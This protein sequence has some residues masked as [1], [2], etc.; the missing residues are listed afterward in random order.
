MKSSTRFLSVN[1]QSEADKR[2]RIYLHIVILTH[3]W[4]CSDMPTWEVIIQ[5]CVRMLTNQHTSTFNTVINHFCVFKPWSRWSKTHSL[6]LTHLDLQ[7]QK[8]KPHQHR[9][10]DTSRG[11]WQHYLE[12]KMTQKLHQLASGSLFWQ[13]TTIVWKQTHIIPSVTSSFSNSL[14]D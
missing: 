5:N 1:Y 13:R 7:T 9:S 4:P 14:L 10:F 2:L 8:G 6:L 12:R 11:S 3:V